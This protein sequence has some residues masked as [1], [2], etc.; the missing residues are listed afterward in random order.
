MHSKNNYTDLEI[1][2]LIVK[3]LSVKTMYASSS[4]YTEVQYIIYYNIQYIYNIYCI[5]IL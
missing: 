4:G 5:T 2:I 1:T 3:C